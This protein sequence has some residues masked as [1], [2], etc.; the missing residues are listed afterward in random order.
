MNR[1][2]KIGLVIC[3]TVWGMALVGN[4]MTDKSTEIRAA[5]EAKLTPQERTE[6]DNLLK[7]Q[8]KLIMLLKQTRATANNP[9][10]IKVRSG[11]V[12]LDGA[13]GSLKFT[14]TNAYGAVIQNTKHF[15]D[16]AGKCFDGLGN[17]I[18]PKDIEKAV[19]LMAADKANAI[20][21]KTSP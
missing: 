1:T 19:D 17:Q 8:A 12:S 7:G 9:E 18:D 14:G 5:E 6:R 15:G 4:Y 2:L 21:P 3:G 11:W 20:T 13:C 10:S 16:T